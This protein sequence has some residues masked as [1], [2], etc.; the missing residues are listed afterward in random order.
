MLL[1]GLLAGYYGRPLIGKPDQQATVPQS[2]APSQAGAGNEELMTYLVSQTRHF[3]GNPD[4]PVTLIEFGDF[5]WPYCGRFAADAGRQI[6]ETYVQT[7]KVRLAFIHFAFLGQESQ[8]AAE[9]SECA[10]EQNAFWE[11]HDF[12]YEHQNGENRGAFSQDNLK[13]FAGQ[14]GLD[15]EAFGQCLD[16]GK[17]T[18]IVKQEIQMAQQLGV[19]S[20]PTF[21]IN[22]TPVVGAQPFEAFQQVIEAA[23]AKWKKRYRYWF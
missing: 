16:S 21:V 8:W 19:Q 2:I 15:E 20:T 22:G 10:A 17:Y 1:I 23:L 6:N 5:Q 13:K 7:G 3:T 18:D 12:L 9:A 11:Y 4:A 14:L